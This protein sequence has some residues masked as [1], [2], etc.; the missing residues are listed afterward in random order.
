MKGKAI[1]VPEGSFDRILGEVK[2]KATYERCGG[3]YV[4]NMT[5][6]DPEVTK[7]KSPEAGFRRQG[8]KR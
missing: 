4:A 2:V 8:V 5:A 3:L 7:N 6:R 1:V